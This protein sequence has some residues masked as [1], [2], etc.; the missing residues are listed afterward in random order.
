MLVYTVGSYVLR[1]DNV[2]ESERT[3]QRANIAPSGPFAALSGYSADEVMEMTCGFCT[4]D[5]TQSQAPNDAAA[6]KNVMHKLTVYGGTMD[7]RTM[8]KDGYRAIA[9]AR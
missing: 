4:V 5:L 6:S 2:Q 1:I 7:S 9:A 8:I 3:G